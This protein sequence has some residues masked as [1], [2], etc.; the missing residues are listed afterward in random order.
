[1]PEVE[2]LGWQVSPHGSL[3]IL[4]L[5][6][7]G[8][9]LLRF[10]S[11]LVAYAYIAQGDVLH[12]VSAHSCYAASVW[13]GLCHIDVRE[14]D[15]MQFADIVYPLS[16]VISPCP[17][18]EAYEYGRL[19]PSDCYSA[20][21]DI[22]HLSSVDNLEGYGAYSPSLP[23]ELCR[24][25]GAG[26]DDYS[27]Y[28]YVLE[29]SVCLCP[30]LYGVTVAADDTVADGHVLAF[31]WRCAL[32]GYGVV[33]AVGEDS[34]YDDVMASVNVYGVVVIVVAVYDVEVREPH[35][36]ACEIVLHPAG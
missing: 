31:P 21:D 36:V 25:V 6:L 15:I 11:S 32:E 30:E 9:A 19:C 24:L 20:D 29:S 26:L 17:V 34:L 13:A 22:V 10:S 1:M 14:H 33:V 28:V 8:H 7:V 5:F 3:R 12:S 16:L 18:G 27:V 2:S 23:E 4:V 35:T